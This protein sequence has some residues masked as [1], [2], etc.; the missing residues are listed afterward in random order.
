MEKRAERRLYLRKCDKCGIEM[1]SVYQQE[2][3]YKV[4]CDECYN[5]KIY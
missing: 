1:I 4:Y 3:D 5:K 2:S